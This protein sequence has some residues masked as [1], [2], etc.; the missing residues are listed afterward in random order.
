MSHFATEHLTPTKVAFYIM[1]GV[2]CLKCK[3]M[4][5]GELLC[6]LS[7]TTLVPEQY[8]QSVYVRYVINADVSRS[9]CRT[10]S[11]CKD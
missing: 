4:K 3:R 1:G 7:R 6:S 8:I 2:K 11:E 10:K 5:K 9:D